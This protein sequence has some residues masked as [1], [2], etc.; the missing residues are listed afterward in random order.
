MQGT[1]VG[2]A[3]LGTPSAPPF[4]DIGREEHC[5]EMESEAV[6]ETH[7][8]EESTEGHAFNLNKEEHDSTCYPGERY[9]DL[10]SHFELFFSLMCASL[11]A[12]M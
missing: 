2:G 3:D 4:M 10:L 5:F 1:P 8:A 7:T 11:V 12:F 9:N 6:H